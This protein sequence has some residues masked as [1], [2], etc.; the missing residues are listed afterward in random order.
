[1]TSTDDK[2]FDATFSGADSDSCSPLRLEP[3]RYLAAV[4]HYAARYALRDAGLTNDQ[5]KALLYADAYGMGATKLQRVM[6]MSDEQVRAA[7]R[8][9]KNFIFSHRG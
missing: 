5:A 2:W 9:V 4:D 6:N 1:M 8:A 3:D 7:R